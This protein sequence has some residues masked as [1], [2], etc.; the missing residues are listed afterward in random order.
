MAG[1]NVNRKWMMWK[2]F[3]S[4]C[5]GLTVVI[6][7]IAFALIFLFPTTLEKN[8][9]HFVI[10]DYLNEAIHCVCLF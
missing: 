5:D 9:K 8:D 10:K 6:V 3:P 1:P 7:I 2:R 4:D